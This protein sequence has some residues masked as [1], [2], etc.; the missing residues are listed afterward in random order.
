MN[1]AHGNKTTQNILIEK[2]AE[3]GV[4]LKVRNNDDYMNESMEVRAKYLAKVEMAAR[5]V[6]ED[7]ET[8]EAES[9]D[10]FYSKGNRKD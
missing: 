10:K 6:R 5:Q 7:R 4:N 1:N 8:S 3:Q 2:M 9:I